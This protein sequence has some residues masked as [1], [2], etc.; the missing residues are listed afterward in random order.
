MTVPAAQRVLDM[1][2]F[3]KAEGYS[4]LERATTVQ[5]AFEMF[6]KHPV[7]G[8]GWSS[9]GSYDLVVNILANA[10][11]IG[12]AAFLVAMYSI[13]RELYRSIKL[14]SRSLGIAGLMQIDFALYIAFAAVLATSSLTGILYVFPFFWSICGLAIAAANMAD[15]PDADAVFRGARSPSPI[16]VQQ[17]SPDSQ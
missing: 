12:L 10:G 3:T 13:F 14:R 4:A 15:F 17:M 6:Q 8:I 9:I 1:A 5:H 11:I 16:N 2:L 7:L